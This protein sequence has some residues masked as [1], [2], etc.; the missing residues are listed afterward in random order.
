MI[1]IMNIKSNFISLV[2]YLNLGTSL[3]ALGRFNE[4]AVILREGSKLDGNGLRDRREHEHA[5]ITSLLVLGQ[6]HVDNGRL[7]RA[8]AIYREA[9]A[10]LPAFL[11][12]QTEK[13]SKIF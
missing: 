12:G 2:A 4:A 3:I 7:Q 10:T 11:Y 1:I 6:L 13:V 5:R 9:L 8:I